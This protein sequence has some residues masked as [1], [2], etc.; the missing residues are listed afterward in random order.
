MKRRVTTDLSSTDRSS[1]LSG[2]EDRSLAFSIAEMATS[3]QQS[4]TLCYIP[5]HKNTNSTKPTHFGGVW[6]AFR[7]DYQPST[8]IGSPGKVA[9]QMTTGIQVD[10]LVFC[11]KIYPIFFHLHTS[12]YGRCLC[13]ILKRRNEQ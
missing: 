1:A 4:A 3:N 5:W 12:I 13:G 11:A 10:P 9:D 2:E 7:D 6:P 8:C